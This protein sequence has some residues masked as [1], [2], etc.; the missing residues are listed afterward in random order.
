M[1]VSRAAGVEVGH[2]RGVVGKLLR[3][4]LG[5]LGELVDLHHGRHQRGAVQRPS[6]RRG[7]GVRPVPCSMQSMP[8]SIRPGSTAVPKQCAVTLAPWSWATRIASANSSG[9]NDG[10]RSPG[11]A[12]DPVADQLDPAVAALR[13]LRDVRRQVL[14]L[15]LV[16]VVADV[17]LRPR[18]VPPGPDQP[19]Q[20]VALVHPGRVGRRPGVADQQRARVPVVDRLLLGDLVGRAAVVVQPEVAVRV[21]QPRHHPPARD[22][23]RPGL[24]LQRDPAVDDVQVPDLAV[25]KH[26]AGHLQSGHRPGRYRRDA[27]GR[28]I[29]GCR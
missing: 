28:F 13:L 21:D 18:D 29:K 9:A 23:L 4:R 11:L 15:D 26:R 17:A 12:A 3:A 2:R 10:S 25:G 5:V 7:P 27:V 14:R 8:A 6:R 19:R 1:I 16:G 20:V 24:L 22:R